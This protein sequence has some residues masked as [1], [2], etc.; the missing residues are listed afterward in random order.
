[1]EE[2]EHRAKRYEDLG[3]KHTYIMDLTCVPLPSP[4][5]SEPQKLGIS[6]SA[7]P[8]RSCSA[9]QIVFV[10]DCRNIS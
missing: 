1:M 8:L 3:L 6:C 4:A 9:R 10:Q 7:A 2:A 5:K